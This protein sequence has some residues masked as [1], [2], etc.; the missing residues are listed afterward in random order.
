M[1]V[2]RLAAQPL[3]VPFPPAW[4]MTWYHTPEGNVARARVLASLSAMDA[5]ISPS[6]AMGTGTTR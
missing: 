3:G 6:C 5:G 2:V 1:V 4:P